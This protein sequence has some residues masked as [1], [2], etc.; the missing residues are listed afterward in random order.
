MNNYEITIMILKSIK[1]I[2]P[3]HND[4]D[5][6]RMAEDDRDTVRAL[7]KVMK[8]VESE[9]EYQSDQ[10]AHSEI[11]IEIESS[12]DIPLT[13]W[14]KLHGINPATARQKAGRGMFKTARKSGRD[15]FINADEPNTDNRH[16]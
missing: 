4:G 2:I 12:G 5:H 13:E 16:K 3:E 14:A 6:S 11:T 15:W 8:L 1:S 10:E 7:E 9:M